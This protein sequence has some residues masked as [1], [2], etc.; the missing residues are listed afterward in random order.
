[1][2]TSYDKFFSAIETYK[3]QHLDTLKQTVKAVFPTT[4]YH[5]NANAKTAFTNSLLRT[6]RR[7]L[8]DQMKVAI[9]SKNLFFNEDVASLMKFVFWLS[10]QDIID[11]NNAFVIMEDIYDCLSLKEINVYFDFMEQSFSHPTKPY[12]PSQHQALLRISNS[13]L[14]KFSKVHDTG[15]R[16]RI[17]IFLTN[18]NYSLSDKMALNLKG[19]V[20]PNNTTY[21]E[22]DVNVENANGDGGNKMEIES[23]PQ[24]LRNVGFCQR[25]WELQKFIHDPGLL[26]TEESDPNALLGN[27]PGEIEVEVSHTTTGG[28]SHSTRGKNAEKKFHAFCEMVNQILDVFQAD[29]LPEK[30]NASNVERYPKYFTKTSLLPIQLKEPYFRKSWLTQTLVCI[31]ALKNPFKFQ[32]KKVYDIT[33]EEK[34]RLDKLE[35]K[36]RLLLSKLKGED[37]IVDLDRKVEIFLESDRHWT[38]WK[39]NN[40]VPFEKT[41]SKE[42]LEVYK[43]AQES[44]KNNVLHNKLAKNLKYTNK[45]SE[46][47]AKVVN[48]TIAVHQNHTQFD[49]ENDLLKMIQLKEGDKLAK[50]SEEPIEPCVNYYFDDIIYEL[51]NPPTR[52]EDKITNN[53]TYSWRALRVLARNHIGIFYSSNPSNAPQQQSNHNEWKIEE[54]TKKMLRG[55]AGDGNAADGGEVGEVEVKEKGNESTVVK[56]DRV[57]KIESV[58]KEEGNKSESKADTSTPVVKIEVKVEAKSPKPDI[59]HEQQQ[60]QPKATEPKQ[61]E[62]QHSNSKTDKIEVKKEIE[63]KDKDSLKQS[64]KEQFREKEVNKETKEH[65]DV[66]DVRDTHHAPAPIREVKDN[67]RDVRERGETRESARGE[68]DN[69]REG[70]NNRDTRENSGRGGDN[71]RDREIRDNRDG[72]D[73]RDSRDPR[74]IREGREIREKGETRDH[75]GNDIKDFGGSNLKATTSEKGQQQ[76]RERG[77]RSQQGGGVGGNKHNQGGGGGQPTNGNSKKRSPEQDL[78]EY[79]NKSTANKKTKS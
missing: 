12:P 49:R 22:S 32:N 39:E 54:L 24:D 14:R 58:K 13:M 21:Y 40:C 15:I 27:E 64:L 26:L 62:L 5:E 1:M 30:E 8:E 7:Y 6:V 45:Y 16:G 55:V 9:K 3:Y 44:L 70:N 72:R 52:E 31:H 33:E 77:E 66:K 75:R 28:G 38:T 42:F 61:I 37:D 71:V 69:T 74:D 25:F 23:L 53:S 50:L 10:D 60:Q 29:P 65:K 73:L 59:R 17:Q 18:I 11:M 51:K 35:E 41:A 48:E 43:Q 56:E 34:F 46:K 63:L 67:T 47:V 36:L 68:R 2:I 79:E 78:R 57:E 19:I 20:N 76:E 4:P